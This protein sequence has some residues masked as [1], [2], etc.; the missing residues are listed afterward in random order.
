MALA[1]AAALLTLW[2]FTTRDDATTTAP[3]PAAPGRP[4]AT[5]SPFAADL[6]LGNVVLAASDDQLAP[7]RA[8]AEAVAGA[9]DPALR[10]AG[11][12]VLVRRAAQAGPGPQPSGVSAFAQGRTLHVAQAGDPALRT[13]VEYWLGRAAP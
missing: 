7:A 11:Q 6:R 4:F 8:L 13:F 1:V 12:A 5:T 3:Q 9:P 2:F 10:T